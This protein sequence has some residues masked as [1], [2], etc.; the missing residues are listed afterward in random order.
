L[1][2]SLEN[3]LCPSSVSAEQRSKP[4]F[5]SGA[6]FPTLTLSPGPPSQILALSVLNHVHTLSVSFQHPLCRSYFQK[7]VSVSKASFPRQSFSPLVFY[8]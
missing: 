4:V 3:P 6:S 7:F 1:S 8:V 5:F 2:L